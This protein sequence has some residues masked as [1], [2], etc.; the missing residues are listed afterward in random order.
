M[1]QIPSFLFQ[2]QPAPDQINSA[3]L[4]GLISPAVQA[5][6]SA[7]QFRQT[8]GYVGSDL[9]YL[10]GRCKLWLNPYPSATLPKGAC[11]L[12][13]EV[14]S[15]GNLTL[16]MNQQ[17]SQSV[18]NFYAE[19]P[20]M[21]VPAFAVHLISP[22]EWQR[23]SLDDSIDDPMEYP[24]GEFYPDRL[25]ETTGSYTQILPG[26]LVLGMYRGLPWY[27]RL[28]D[29]SS[30]W[31]SE[32][33]VVIGNATTATSSQS[34]TY[35]AENMVKLASFALSGSAARQQIQQVLQSATTTVAQKA[36]ALDL[37]K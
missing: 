1:P 24:L 10:N 17:F 23:F 33:R 5:F 13:G 28:G 8:P 22:D 20:S 37:L 30:I 34:P 36:Q 14:L 3:H 4:S 19:R 2:S 7:Q 6:A 21:Q 25:N 29:A 35:P 26:S 11:F 27:E 12:T 32:A 9:G 31:P 16:T 15:S 18:R